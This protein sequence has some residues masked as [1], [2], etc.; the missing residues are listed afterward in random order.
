[1]L[2]KTRLEVGLGWERILSFVIER[3]CVE[4]NLLCDVVRFRAHCTPPPIPGDPSLSRLD[5]A[6]TALCNLETSK[7]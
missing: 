5:T 3:G 4:L 1:M 7:L 6:Y 2:S